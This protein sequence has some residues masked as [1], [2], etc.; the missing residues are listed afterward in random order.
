MEFQPSRQLLE[1]ASWRVVAEIIRCYPTIRVIETHPGGGQYDC[2][3]LLLDPESDRDRPSLAFN[4][5]GSLHV[6]TEGESG[7]ARWETF[8]ADYLA[9][10]DPRDIVH[11]VCDLA[12]LPRVAHLPPST[13]ATI[14]YRF[15]AAFLSS[16]VFG[17]ARWECRNGVFDTSA[18]E[19][20]VRDAFATFPAARA[21]LLYREPHDVLGEPAYRFWFLGNGTPRL[22]LETTGH[23][24]DTE[25]NEFDLASLYRKRRRLWP[26]V[27][28]VARDLLY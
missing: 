2:L 14:V 21:R 11:R 28:F 16:T 4:R 10:E 6:F 9:A 25:G 3:Q 1:A 17:R 19:G 23:A 12:R 15:I 22:C 24:W 27:S 5:P 8:W 7:D 26:V 13:P 18:S 20:G